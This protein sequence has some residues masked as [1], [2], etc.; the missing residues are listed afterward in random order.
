MR[1]PGAGLLAGAAG[2]PCGTQRQGAGLG[3]APVGLPGRS[4]TLAG[5]CVIQ[6]SV[7]FPLSFLRGLFVALLP[8]AL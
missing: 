7:P 5:V 1:L 6:P 3:A 2:S 4:C 8:I